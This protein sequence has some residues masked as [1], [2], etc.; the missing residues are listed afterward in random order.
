MRSRILLLAL[1]VTAFPAFG[2]Q[3][4]TTDTNCQVNG[5]QIN[6]TSQHVP[7][8]DETYNK[9]RNLLGKRDS[10]QPKNA[11]PADAGQL[12]PEA[13]KEL[14]AQEKQQREAKDTVDFIYCR[15]NPKSGITDSDGKPKTCADVIEYT[16]AFCLVNPELER[17][18]LAK[19]KTEVQKAFAALAEDYNT[20]PRRK[21][22]DVQE[23]FD[24][25]FAKLTRWGCMS[26]SDMSLP[27]RDGTMHLCPDAPEPASIHAEPGPHTK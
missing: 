3:S 26:F 13:I 4:G 1:F 24:S 27:Q 8:W 5:S 15:Q 16:K 9:Y 21:K 25:Q 7:S 11:A 2:Q 18:T 20:D 22:K 14:F 19:S 23:Y 6:C 10:D 17:C 12:S